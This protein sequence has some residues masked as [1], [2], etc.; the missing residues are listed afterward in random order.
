[1][2]QREHSKIPKNPSP[3]TAVRAVSPTKLLDESEY[4]HFISWA[5]KNRETVVEGSYMQAYLLR[6]KTKITDW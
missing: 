6:R 1:M 4:K 5:E 2:R 3:N